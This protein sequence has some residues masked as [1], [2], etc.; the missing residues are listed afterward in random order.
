MT[1]RCPEISQ[2]AHPIERREP[3]P[4]AHPK[5]REEDAAEDAWVGIRAWHKANGSALFNGDSNGQT[6][7]TAK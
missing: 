1:R 7:R 4:W 3:L 2:P 6:R 5:S